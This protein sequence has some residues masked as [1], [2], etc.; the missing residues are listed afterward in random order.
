MHVHGASRDNGGNITQWECVNEP[1][2]K[3]MLTGFTRID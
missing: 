2:V 3:W 1:N